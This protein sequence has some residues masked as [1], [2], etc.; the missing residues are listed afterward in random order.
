VRDIE[1]THEVGWNTRRLG[2]YQQL[3]DRRGRGSA[4]RGRLRLGRYWRA[5]PGFAM[6]RPPTAKTARWCASRSPTPIS[7][8]R[9]CAAS[10][11]AGR[12][13]SPAE[14]AARDREAAAAHLGPRR[15]KLEE[16]AVRG[17]RAA[18]L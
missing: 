18:C 8:R 17:A 1:V 4:P 9:R 2:N 11:R 13:C 5:A 15:R 6:R 16:A 3:R 10:A 12:S 14:D 7:M